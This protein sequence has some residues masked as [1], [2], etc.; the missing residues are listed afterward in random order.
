M[1]SQSK[2]RNRIATSENLIFLLVGIAAL[3]SGTLCA[4]ETSAPLLSMEEAIQ[5]AIANN[6]SLKIAKL[7][8]EKSKWQVAEFKTKRLPSLSGTILGSQLLNEV[9][10]AFPA[11]AFGTI[12]GVGPFP[13]T[14][15]KIRT[16]RQPVAYISS[17]A[18][19]P[20][21]QLYQIHL[22]LRAQELGTQISS[23]KARAEKQNLIKDVKQAYYAI[24]QSQSELESAEASVKQY[25]E[26]DRVVLQRVS[27]QAALQSDSL[28]VKARFSNEKYKL[29][30]LRNTLDSRREYLNHLLG[31]DIRTDFRVEQ[32]PV[33]SFEEI[34]LKLAQNRALEQRPEIRQSELS[35]RQAEYDRRIAKAD[36]IPDIGVAFNYSSNFNIDV[37]PR[38]MTS[39]GFELKWEPW[40]WGRRKDVVSQKKVVETQ[41]QAKLHEVQSR[42]LLDVNTR[43]RKLEESR[44]L[45]SVAEA[46]RDATQ[47]R[48]R[49]IT[50]KYAQEAVLLSDVLKQQTAAANARDDYQQAV[51]GF[52]SAK[53]EFEKSLG[54]DQ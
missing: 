17:Q 29:I 39:I 45:I 10:F 8:V 25:Q 26:L 53:T 9:S 37:L 1:P 16:P 50:N 51:L 42:V 48:L 18:A 3:F 14:E 7:D 11:G 43:F 13:S 36:Y 6:Q 30:Q 2:I 54:E 33:A 47:Q 20:L 27:Q 41:A 19:Q 28:D 46:Q 21:S 24:L 38:N 52:W 22:G 23:E 49:E 32:V 15:T 5:L 12:P 35:L 34:D 4:Q 40:D 31:R 44:A